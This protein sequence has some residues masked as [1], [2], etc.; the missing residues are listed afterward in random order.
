MENLYKLLRIPVSAT[1]Y[2]IYQAFWEAL[3]IY[4]KDDTKKREK[5]IKAFIV[6]SDLNLRKQYDFSLGLDNNDDNPWYS[7]SYF[8]NGRNFFDINGYFCCDKELTQEIER[9]KGDKIRSSVSKDTY[10]C[11]S[12][13]LS[14]LADYTQEKMKNEE[15]VKYLASDLN[16][17]DL[18]NIEKFKIFED[19]YD[20]YKI[21]FSFSQDFV[22]EIASKDY[23]LMMIDDATNYRAQQLLI[24]KRGVCTHFAALMYEE[25]KRL[26]LEAY[27]LRMILPRWYHHVVLYRV[28]N[29]W[30]ICDLTNEYLNG[31][32]GYKFL[33]NNYMNIPLEE[34][35]KNNNCCVHTTIIPKTAKDTLADDSCVTLYDFLKERLPKEISNNFNK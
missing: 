9:I 27:Y 35:I 1:D 10:F 14:K 33:G 29:A 23:D 34:F 11:K 5:Y 6:L 3:C 13:L 16:V 12:E 21:G 2:E 25:L 26:G 22:L 20:S 28:G 17:G 7:Y 31:E 24:S 32:A 30:Y 8:A 15:F 19:I 4:A 18:S